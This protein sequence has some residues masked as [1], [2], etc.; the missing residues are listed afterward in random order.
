MA[1][2]AV[3]GANLEHMLMS[4]VAGHDA[5]AIQER[6]PTVLLFVPSVNGI[7][8]SPR[9]LTKDE[10]LVAGLKALVAVLARLIAG[11]SEGRP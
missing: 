3:N 7:S 8:H 1:T 6:W 5:I 9:E 4:T 2:D 11:K 10:D